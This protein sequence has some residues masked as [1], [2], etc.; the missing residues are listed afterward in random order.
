MIPEIEFRY[1]WIY[2]TQIEV[3][4]RGDKKPP[5]YSDHEIKEFYKELNG[6]IRK[7]NI[8]WSKE[9]KDI[10]KKIENITKLK[11]KERKII[12]YISTEIKN[13]FSDPLTMSFDYRKDLKNSRD[14]LTH[15][16]LHQIQIQND[17]RINKYYSFLQK[18]YP[19]A[20]GTVH[21]H[22]FVHAALKKIYLELIGEDRLKKDIK[23]CQKWPAY[24]RAWTIVEEEGYETILKKFKELTK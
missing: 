21:S 11:W 19:K 17:S 24:K 4:K 23:K 18:K 14:V 12:V 9:G 20:N 8:V 22:I 3:F 6:Y 10:L 5:T 16:L 2:D 15:E 7:L 13:A 1:S